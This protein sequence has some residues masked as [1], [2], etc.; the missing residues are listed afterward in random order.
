MKRILKLLG[1]LITLILIAAIIINFRGIP[2][3]EVVAIDHQVVSTPEQIQKGKKVVATLCAGCHMNQETGKLTGKLMSDVPKEF[4]VV[5]SPNITQDKEYGIGEWTDSELILLLRTGIKRDGKYA[6][7]YMAKL[8]NMAD[9]DIDAIISFLKSDNQLV[10]ADATPDKACEPSFL[11]KFLCT[12]AFKPLPLP[13]TKLNIPDTAD[14]IKYGRYLAHN[15]DCFSC[16]SA[17]FKTVDFLHPTKSDGYFGGG[18]KPL[19]QS[20]QVIVTANLTPDNE[21][22]IGQWSKDEFIAAVKYGTKKDEQALRYPMIPYTLL[23]DY[24]VSCIYDYLQTI[25]PI[26]NNIQ[27]TYYD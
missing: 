25:P 19:N 20:G 1:V 15:Y 4:G 17:D 5:Y 23:T 13:L 18:N 9:S 22:G 27:R 8:P 6:P 14:A 12:V 16:H 21:T 24:E 2:S 3:Y 10:N 7:P 11:T 26:S